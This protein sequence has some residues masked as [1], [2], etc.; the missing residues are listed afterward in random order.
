MGAVF[1]DYYRIPQMYFYTLGGQC[2]EMQNIIPIHGAK[3]NFVLNTKFAKNE[4]ALQYNIWKE[5]YIV[6]SGNVFSTATD[7]EDLPDKDNIIFGTSLALGLRTPFGK[8]EYSIGRNSYNSDIY[9]FF[10]VGHRF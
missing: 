5:L 7:L 1:G 3:K 8:L 6:Q 10:N 2:R 9:H 4:I